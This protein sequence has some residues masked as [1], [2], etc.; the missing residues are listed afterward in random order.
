VPAAAASAMMDFMGK[1]F[2]VSVAFN[3]GSASDGS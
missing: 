1:S 2:L 3:A